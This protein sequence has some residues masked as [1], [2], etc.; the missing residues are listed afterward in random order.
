MSNGG[1]LS[2]LNDRPAQ[3]TF[4]V[5]LRGYDKRQLD[6]YVSRADSEIATLAAER[7]RAVHHIQDLVARLQHL[8]AELTE[9][10]Q[11]PARVDRA[12]FRHLGPMVD[13]IL[14]LAEKQAEA[15]TSTTAQ[16][17]ANRQAEAEKVLVEAREQA[18]RALRDLE[19]EVAARRA[20][21]EKAHE[22]RRA[23]A[24]A[25][26]AEIRALA[27]RSRAESEAARERAQQEANRISEQSTQQLEQARAES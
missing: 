14:A 4:E 16:R 1:E 15:I 13:Q 27:D 12:S 19:V 10:R 20:D 25:E 18:A 17:A 21:G 2:V 26:L 6:Q 7:E 5:S 24:Q 8:E 11:R 3:P 23:A 22:E 9:L